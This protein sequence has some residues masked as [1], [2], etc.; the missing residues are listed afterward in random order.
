MNALLQIDGHEV[1]AF[2]DPR[3]STKLSAAGRRFVFSLMDQAI[4]SRWDNLSHLRL[5]VIQF[6]DART[7]ARKPIVHYDTGVDLWDPEE[8]ATMIDQACRTWGMAL[9][10]DASDRRRAAS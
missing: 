7:E 10:D 1:I 4:R 2:V 3:R 6:D 8:L 5:A 9:A